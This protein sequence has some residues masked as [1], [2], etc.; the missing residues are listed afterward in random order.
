MSKQQ[1]QQ[2]NRWVSNLKDKCCCGATKSTP[3]ECMKKGIQCSAKAP[4]CPCYKLLDKQTG[5]TKVGVKKYA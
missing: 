3:C 1:F 2:D 5:K 4:K